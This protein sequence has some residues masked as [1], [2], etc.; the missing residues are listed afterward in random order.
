M[1]W[2][3]M[4][5]AYTF[6]DGLYLN[7]TDRCPTDCTF[8]MKGPAA[9]GF[10]GAD[11]T[12]SSEPTLDQAWSAVLASAA[13]APFRELVFCGYGE[14]TYRLADML[15]LSR[16]ARTAFPDARLRLNTVG[17]GSRIHGRDI[18]PELK[19]AL[20]AVCVS[21]NTADP[22]QWLKLLRPRPEF[23]EG[24]FESVLGFVRACAASGLDTTVTAVELPTVD[25]A[26][27]AAL[28]RT[29]GASFRPRPFL[30]GKDVA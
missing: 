20:D 12:L 7:L 6:Q 10:R 1:M 9:R 28:A 29:L 5:I 11:L 13:Q 23:Q 8:C 25:L 21:L 19:G 30:A 15:E 27:V 14:S 2:V 16:R 22:G 17:L 26:A 3:E 24:G 4:T 18:V